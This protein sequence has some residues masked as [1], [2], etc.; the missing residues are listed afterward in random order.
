[1]P[2]CAAGFIK[3]VLSTRLVERLPETPK[4]DEDAAQFRPETPK[5][6]KNASPLAALSTFATMLSIQ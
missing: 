4:L 2:Y 3:G 5:Q 6:H 1:M